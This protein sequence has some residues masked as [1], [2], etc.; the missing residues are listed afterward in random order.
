MIIKAAMRLAAF[1][2]R[3]GMRGGLKSRRGMA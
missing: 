1:G 2:A 3:H